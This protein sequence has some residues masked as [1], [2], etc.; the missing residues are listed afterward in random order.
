LP[1]SFAIFYLFIMNFLRLGILSALMS[2]LASVA[3]AQANGSIGGSVTDSLGAIVPGATVTAVAA[4]G[5]EKQAVANKNGEYVITGL[6]PGTYTV[7]STATN[8]FA[9]YEN[10]TVEVT[11]AE[12]TDLIIVLTVSGVQAQV[13]V[14]LDTGVSTDPEANKDATVIKG[15]DLDALPDDPDELSSALQALAG[16]SAGPNGGQIYIDGFLGGQLPPKESIREIRINQNPFSAEF[17]RMGF[18]RIEILTKPGTDKL[19]GSFNFNFNDNR[20]NSRNPFAPFRAPL[21]SKTFG[22]NLSGPLQKKKSSFFLDVNQRIVDNNS[23][24]NAEILDPS[25][26][27]T[28]FQQEVTVPTKRL[29]IAPRFDFQIGSRNTLVARYSYSHNS[30]A[31][32][33]L[34]SGFALPSMA[35]NSG[36]QEHEIRLT[37]T[38]IINPKT[39]NET[40][41]EISHSRNFQN[42]GTLVPVVS[43]A[44]AFTT[45]GAQVGN[46]FSSNTNFELNN[47]TATSLGKNSQHSVK[48][49]G[50][51]RHISLKSQS[52][53]G[54]GG[55]FSFQGFFSRGNAVDNSCDIIQQ[56]NGAIVS[57]SD[58]IIS[59]IEQYRCKVLG[60][61]DAAYNPQQFT[62][63]AGNPL[64]G[65]SQTE[66]A[67]WATDD[68][69]VSPS[70]LLSFGLR[71]ENQSNIHSNLNFAPRFG[72]AWSPGSGGAKSPKTVFRGGAGVFYERFGENNTLTALR[73]NGVNQL[74]FILNSRDPDPT[75]QAIARNFLNQATFTASGGVTNAPTAAQIQAAL[76]QSNTIRTVASDLSAPYTIQAA[77][78]IER[79]LPQSWRTTLTGTFIFSRGIHQLRVRDVN[80]PVCPNYFMPGVTCTGAPRPN[81]AL[82]NVFAFE[83]SGITEQKQAIIQFRTTLSTKLSINGSYRLGFARGNTDGGGLAAGPAYAYDL[84]NE[85][86]RTAFDV[87][88]SFTL[89]GNYSGPWGVSIA[90]FIVATSGRPFNIVTGVD[91]NGDTLFLERPTFG[92]LAGACSRFNV[93][94]P[95]CNVSG[96][97]PSAIIPRNWGQGPSSFS[98]NLRLSKTIGFGKSPATVARNGNG[99]A[100]GT[101]GNGR[102]GRGG[103]G[104]QRGGSAGGFPGGGR[105]GGGGGDGG[106]RGG[107]GGFFGGGESRKPYNMNFG[108]NISN[109]LN[110]VNLS[111]PIG[112]LSSVRFGQSLSTAGGFGGFGGGGGSGPNRRI[113]LFMRFSF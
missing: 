59:P 85:W 8:K 95:Y 92:V 69:K 68:W 102:G 81:P 27:V 101:G 54:Y 7:R 82:T 35:F 89:F 87:R 46:S 45:G 98:M 44:S 28:P 2:L 5:T 52:E 106:P 63:T 108:V 76:P 33:G 25:F 100:N 31:N 42:G 16:A 61:G 40:R 65:I 3:L 99:D 11:G 32:Q 21:Q 58:G 75:R 51:L 90:P 113:E 93:T 26:T 74:S 73:F 53:N 36:S 15:K 88:H 79:Q 103:A 19:R 18:G 14:S 10:T 47:F 57:G 97:D 34:N 13:D 111:P 20:L 71:Y 38:Q 80:A 6:K 70:L 96:F 49:G 12:R 77:L 1:A 22:G 84:S 66:E 94:A 83:S 24:I 104:G 64:Q 50:R 112:N 91:A 29:T 60:I 39:V 9:A 105:P 56:Q 62:I 41:V 109:L 48:F 107:G 78:S 72:F 30:S 110:N 4:D 17:D 23:I 43:V 67:L 86:G 55:N 37:D